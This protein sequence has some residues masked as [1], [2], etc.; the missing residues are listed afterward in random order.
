MS[1]LLKALKRA[2]QDRRSKLQETDEPAAVA[3]VQSAPVDYLVDRHNPLLGDSEDKKSAKA[4]EAPRSVS[5]TAL[6]V[7]IAVAVM[8][9]GNLGYWVRGRAA[10]VPADP[11]KGLLVAGHKVAGV[12]HALLGG[13]P[14]PL[15]LRL[16][17]RVDLQG[18]AIA[19]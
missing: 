6:L 16:D 12:P 19:R 11:A 9:A 13:E 14:V 2:E 15:A 7:A 10:T 5:M 4:I 18:P 17:R 3:E 8:L 1:N